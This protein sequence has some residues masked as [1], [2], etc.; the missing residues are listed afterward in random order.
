MFNQYKACAS[1]ARGHTKHT[2]KLAAIAVLYALSTQSGV[3][4][5]SAQ[6][7]ETIEV[8]GQINSLLIESDLDL[9]TSSSPDLRKQLTTLP[10]INVNGN[11]RVSGI[12]QYR[13]LFSDRVRVTIDDTLIAGAGPNAMDSPLS[14]VIGNMSQQVTLYHSIAPVSAGPETLGGALDISDIPP[15]YTSANEFEVAG[16]VMLGAFNNDGKSVSAMFN[17]VNKSSYFG[18]IADKQRGDSYESGRGSLVPNTHYDRSGIKLSAGYQ[19]GPHRA[20]IYVSS[21]DTGESGTPALAMDIQFVDALV[22]GINYEYSINQDWSLVAKLSAN[23]NEHEMDNFSQ[24]ATPM[25]AMYRLN[26][27]DSEGRGAELV[28]SDNSENWS[29][30]FG[31]SFNTAEHNSRI[32]NPNAGAFFLQNFNNVNRELSSI[33]AEWQNKTKQQYGVIEWQFGT[34]FSQVNASADEIDSNMAMMN[35]NV[36]TLRDNFNNTDRD[37][38]FNLLDMVVKAS[39]GITDSI[40]LQVGG[41]LKQKAPSYNQLFSWFPLGV[42]AG[43]ADGRNY[44]G[45]TN[46]QKES[47]IKADFGLLLSGKN[48]R[49]TPNV[50]YSDI[51]DYILGVS[52]N[53]M[54]ANMIA[55]MNNIQIPLVWQNQDARL[56]GIDF[57]YAYS[58]SR[59]LSFSALGQYV[60]AKQTD[61]IKQ[62]LYRIAPLSVDLSLKWSEEKYDISILSRI[63]AAQDKVAEL[64]NESETAGY[65]IVDIQAKYFFSPELSLSFVAENLFDKEYANHLS[66][67][68]RVRDADIAVG[69]KLPSAGRNLGLYMSYQF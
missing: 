58:V 33:F 40:K 17:A 38:D 6:T 27:V 69:D 8:R 45:N 3:S 16:A 7:V 25:P 60:R 41:A 31:L 68:N 67:V 61:D 56:Y 23:N 66:G 47:A 54:V 22:A 20:S 18:I 44:L 10:S 30:Q 15:K 37:L 11:G 19:N 26:T 9:S 13:G 46:L 12:V 35:P 55:N 53:N 48:W 1:I 5:T 52:S 50:F 49:F 14:H 64:Q 62:D 43:L 42:S 4:K 65:A 63:V 39:Y 29:N 51:D 34:R 32:T 28:L 36:R 57:S 21:R 59:Q 24:R 2:L